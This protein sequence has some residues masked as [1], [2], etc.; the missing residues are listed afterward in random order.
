MKKALLHIIIPVLALL[1]LLMPGLLR[2]QEKTPPAYSAYDLR[3]ERIRLINDAVKITWKMD[4]LYTGDFVLGRSEQEFN[5]PA[6]VLNSRLIGTFNSSQ[7]GI[8]IDRGLQPGRKYF[9]VIIAKEDL[10]KR[11]IKLIND[12][13][14]T[15]VPV[16][17]FAEPGPVES[18]KCEI[19]E[20]SSI[21]VTWTKA[22]GEKLK[23]NIYRSKS[24]ISARADLEVAEKVASTE[25]NSYTDRNVPDY[26][27]YFY[28]VTI[29]DRNDIEYFTPSANNNYAISGIYIKGRT[30][31]T[32]LNTGAFLGQNNAI[33]VKWE[34]GHSLTGKSIAGYEIYRSEEVI[35]SQLK[36]KFA[37][38]LHIAGPSETLYTDASPG[39]GKFYYAVFARYN[40][41]TVDIN[42][43]SDSNFTRTPV[44]IVSDFRVTAM[45]AEL[46]E[47]KIIIKWNY[48]GNSGNETVSIFRTSKPAEDSGM[49]MPD[50]IIATE[51]IKTGTFTLQ[52]PPKGLFY[53]GLFTRDENRVVQFRSGINITPAPLGIKD[54][55][56]EVIAEEKKEVP[57]EKKEEIIIPE[58]KEEII[59]P[60]K[61]PVK[62]KEAVKKKGAGS[63]ELDYIIKTL[64]YSEEY[65]AAV[66]E[67]NL[68]ISGTDNDYDR[69]KA[70]LYLARSY[71]ELEEFSKSVRLL[72]MKDVRHYF[73][74]EAQFW[75]EF[76]TARLK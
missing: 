35:D 17:L 48:T 52:V 14:I 31:T 75:A 33:I 26:G 20:T 51:N 15:V 45:E 59:I 41:G 30:L 38:L 55:K 56:K 67:L 71:I 10:I 32:P 4:T 29:T 18:L 12:V 11:D 53:Y 23:Y 62:K 68:F 28:A 2:A 36:L 72:N 58:E 16:S 64:F 47:G 21:R 22:K 69:A 43:D 5:N 74:D 65:A 61:K 40:D 46:F 39:S 7:E 13:N 34:Q 6:D 25:E 1:L 37:R 3:A 9:Y 27:T 63:S 66:K 76:A 49:L 24:M 8:I 42:F 19:F 44:M 73:P 50:S 57:A 70:R 54:E 60:E